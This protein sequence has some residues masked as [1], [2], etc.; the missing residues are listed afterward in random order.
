[1]DILDDFPEKKN[2][3]SVRWNYFRKEKPIPESEQLT[4]EERKKL[5]NLIGLCIN[6]VIDFNEYY[7]KLAEFW[8]EV[9]EPEYAKEA[10]LRVE[11]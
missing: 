7:T 3:D 9:G 6:R 1:M 2:N 10:L 4:D 11:D 8:N 5:T